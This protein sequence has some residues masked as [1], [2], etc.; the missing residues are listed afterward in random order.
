MAFN[1]VVIVIIILPFTAWKTGSTESCAQ[2][3]PVPWSLLTLCKRLCHTRQKQDRTSR[4]SVAR[5]PLINWQASPSEFA[6]IKQTT[7]PSL[8]P[9]SP[10]PSSHVICLR[11]LSYKYSPNQN[12]W[13]KALGELRAIHNL[14]QRNWRNLNSCLCAGFKNQKIKKKSENPNLCNTFSAVFP[15]SPHFPHVC[16]EAPPGRPTSARAR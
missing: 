14:H 12:K 16:N 10:A 13:L 1:V 15:P 11:D 4:A 2:Q 7:F 8:L 3:R 5:K 9:T 6:I